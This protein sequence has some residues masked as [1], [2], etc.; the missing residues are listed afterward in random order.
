MGGG[1]QFAKI[2]P[3]QPS[4]LPSPLIRLSG[5]FHHQRFRLAPGRACPQCQALAPSG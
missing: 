3:N 4:A 5:P 1:R 2:A